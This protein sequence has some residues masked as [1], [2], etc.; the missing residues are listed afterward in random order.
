[1]TKEET[2]YT[3]PRNHQILAVWTKPETF[4]FPILCLKKRKVA[5]KKKTFISECFIHIYRGK[6]NS[7]R[8]ARSK[9]PWS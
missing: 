9:L 8:P 4:C 3:M 5:D 1:M 2:H 6:C 7:T